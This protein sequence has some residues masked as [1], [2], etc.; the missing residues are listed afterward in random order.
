MDNQGEK[1]RLAAL[2]PEGGV[3]YDVSGR[4]F[5]EVLINLLKD[6]PAPASLSREELLK[7]VL[8]REALM[9]TAIGRGIALPHPRTPL[10]NRAEEQFLII[11]FLKNPVDWGALDGIP[12]HTA[13]LVVSASAREHLHTLSE[14]NFFCRQE[15]FLKLLENRASRESLIT[16]I[17]ETEET[18]KFTTPS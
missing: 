13:L 1:Q 15:S 10:I 9:P 4:N 16:A 7:A 8:E 5:T 12:V 3:F 14:L 11:A 6:I 17:R 2:I 18:W